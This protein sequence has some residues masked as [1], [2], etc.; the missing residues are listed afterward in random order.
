MFLYLST[1]AVPRVL[2]IFGFAGAANES[3]LGKGRSVTV[4]APSKVADSY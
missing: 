4:I 3:C 2:I 1:N